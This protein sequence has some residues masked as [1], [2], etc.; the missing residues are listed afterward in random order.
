[1]RQGR[2]MLRTKTEKGREFS[3]K[4]PDLRYFGEFSDKSEILR[5]ICQGVFA[6]EVCLALSAFF[7]FTQN[8][9]DENPSI[10]GIGRQSAKASSL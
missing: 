4:I 7:I 5:L 6:P 8:F 2:E 1:M 10:F 3:G 9:S